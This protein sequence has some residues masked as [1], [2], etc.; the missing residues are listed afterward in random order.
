MSMVTSFSHVFYVTPIL[1]LCF[2][3]DC[4]DW[5]VKASNPWL[6]SYFSPVSY[7]KYLQL[8]HFAIFKLDFSASSG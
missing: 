3:L 5:G 6:T 7:K 8:K 1:G 2:A 4:K